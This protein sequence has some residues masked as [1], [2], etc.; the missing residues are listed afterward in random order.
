[1]TLTLL[2]RRTTSAPC[3]RASSALAWAAARYTPNFQI[4]NLKDAEQVEEESYHRVD[5]DVHYSCRWR[6]SFL[7]ELELQEF[8]FDKQDFHI[9]LMCVR[10][11]VLIL[12]LAPRPLSRSL[13][14]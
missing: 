5:Q 6:G 9:R 13:G 8:P 11:C 14:S 12:L 1:M 10:G 2:S 3:A 7:E 4:M